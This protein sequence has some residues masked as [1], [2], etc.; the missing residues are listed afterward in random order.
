MLNDPLA[1]VLSKIMNAERKG[2]RECRLPVN[3]RTIQKVLALMNEHQYLGAFEEVQEEVRGKSLH[4]HLLGRINKC[5]VIKPR[6]STKSDNYEKWEKR[7][8]PAKDFGILIISTPQGVVTHT[9]AKELH[10]GGVL[11]AYCY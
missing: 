6:F 9:R 4:V 11:L 3:S 7:Y 8:L 1:A 2:Q 5:G 10:T